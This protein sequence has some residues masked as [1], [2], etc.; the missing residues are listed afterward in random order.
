MTYKDSDTLKTF[1]SSLTKEQWELAN[2]MHFA[3]RD[4][5]PRDYNTINQ[6]INQFKSMAVVYWPDDEDKCNL[7]ADLIV[8]GYGL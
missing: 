3:L 1:A 7:Y 5:H 6:H 8:E 2:R 4:M